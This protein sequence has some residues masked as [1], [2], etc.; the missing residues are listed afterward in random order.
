MKE[1]AA[2]QSVF[3]CCHVGCVRKNMTAR[4]LLLQLYMSQNN[5]C[6]YNTIIIVIIAFVLC[7]CI[8]AGFVIDI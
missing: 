1:A 3:T 6:N 2:T 8:Y 4:K 7:L 5:N